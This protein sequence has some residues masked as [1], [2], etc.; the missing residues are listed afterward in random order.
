MINEKLTFFY[1]KLLV[2]YE[3]FFDWYLICLAYAEFNHK[4]NML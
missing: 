3:Y 1:V 2:K 4:N